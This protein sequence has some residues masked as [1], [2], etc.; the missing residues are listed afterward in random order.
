LDTR[1]HRPP[2]DRLV[3]VAAEAFAELGYDGTTMEEIA[4]R[5]GISRATLYRRYASR[6]ALFVAV[7]LARADYY[8]TATRTR[9][10]AGG[11]GADLED[12][13]VLGVIEMPADPVLGVLYGQGNDGLRLVLSNPRFRRAIVDAVRPLLTR[14]RYRGELRPELDFDAVIYWLVQQ[15]FALVARGPWEEDA[16]RQYVRT[17]MTPVLLEPARPEARDAG[18]LDEIV[19]RL[20]RIESQLDQLAEA[21]RRR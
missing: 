15:Q 4:G 10:A 1:R 16:L 3:E 20:T 8:F 12:S 7:V 6:E 5:A 19:T 18:Q 21:R 2:A 11:L 13:T 9:A 14:W 17:F